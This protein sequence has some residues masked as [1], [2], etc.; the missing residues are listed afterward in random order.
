M[1][2]SKTETITME[3]SSGY[4]KTVRTLKERLDVSQDQTNKV[5][6][7]SAKALAD[8]ADML[9]DVAQLLLF[10]E[11]VDELEIDPTY[12]HPVSILF[13][14]AY[15]ELHIAEHSM[16]QAAHLRWEE[17]KNLLKTDGRLQG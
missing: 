6:P 15:H 7:I 14:R 13:L 5:E 10:E 12:V 3:V 11:G 17:E 4:A 8:I 2:N 16:R 1:N 9:A